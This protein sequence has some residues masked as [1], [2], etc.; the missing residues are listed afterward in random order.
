MTLARVMALVCWVA[1]SILAQA[2]EDAP[3]GRVQFPVPDEGPVTA[4][5]ITQ[6][7]SIQPGGQT[8]IGVH[9][10]LEEGWH[11]YA[12]EPGDAGL[13]TT[14][15]WW[16]PSG[17]LVGAVEWPPA[18]E[19]L[20]PG[21]IRTYGYQGTTV[22][23]SLFGVNRGMAAGITVPIRAEV[24]W[25]ACKEICIPGSAT[26]ELSLP[27]TKDPPAFSTHAQLFEQTS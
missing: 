22:L 24:S 15:S 19:F 11:I 21:D 12:K 2:A 18:E 16:A 14:V 25:L 6:H 27:V 13:P 17:T 23:S 3:S 26:L 9:F 8:R 5:L 1:G 20:D 4:E 7:A 10:E